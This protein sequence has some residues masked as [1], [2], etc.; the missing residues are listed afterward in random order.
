MIIAVLSKSY[1]KKKYVEKVFFQGK[2]YKLSIK[3]NIYNFR[4]N[5]ANKTILCS[6]NLNIKNL[7]M[8][9]KLYIYNA[10]NITT[11]KKL[12]KSLLKIRKYNTHT[13]RGIY[14]SSINLNKRVGRISGYM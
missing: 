2:S 10:T 5:R 1:F 12:N 11:R 4:F 3:A 6:T 8:R 7:G 14:S 9:K 13:L